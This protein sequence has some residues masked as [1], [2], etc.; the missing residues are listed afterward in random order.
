[1]KLAHALLQ[2]L[3]DYGAEEIFGIPGDFALP[4]FR[5]IERSNI[6]P[7]YTLS[8]EPAVG[9]AADSAA[10]YRSS[11]SVA[12]VTYGAGGLNMINPVAQAYAEKSPVVI[13]SGAPGANEGQ[14]GLGLHHQVKHLGTQLQVFSEV[15]CAQTVLDDPVQ[16]P[17]EIAR[18]LT[19]AR[20]LSRPVYIEFPRDKVDA[21]VP[22][23]PPF[24]PS[25]TD[26]DAARAAA[27][28]ILVRLAAAQNPALL[29]CVEVRRYG[30][31]RK[32]EELAR[33][34]AIPAATTFMARGI[35]A[36][37]DAPFIGTY[38]GLAGD[39]SVR[40]AIEGSDALLMLGVILC[41]TNFG[42]SEKLIDRRRSMH[43]FDRNVRI[44]HHVYPDV[45]LPALIDALLEHAK[46]LGR[47]RP[48]P[49]PDYTRLM[50]KDTQ[51]V[52][53]AD[54]A[55]AV[56]D[57]FDKHGRMPI[58]CDMGDCLFT[59]MDIMYTELVA[60]AYYGTM[61]P[62]VPMGLGMQ[63]ASGKRGL[64]MVGDGAFQMTGWE[65]GNARRLGLNPIVLVLNNAA[66]GMLKVLQEGTHYN[67]LDEWRFAELGTALGGKGRRVATRAELAEALEAAHADDS[68][69]HLVEIMI[70]RGE[71]S[72]TLSRF[73]KAM[74]R[75]SVLGK[76]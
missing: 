47:P 39:D 45:P 6:L 68:T 12:A 9:F 16:A 43:A 18:V 70:P 59:A 26:P 41:D 66:W 49:W 28:E 76:G 44:A 8:H 5:E 42:V 67:D 61:G 55:T 1:M 57:L 29:I 34:L 22:A 14:L 24:V 35:L 53:P 27:S 15:T 38:L 58:A 13:V 69:W 71:Y 75:R 36:G 19:A 51:P 46:P 63:V 54:V 7:L 62:G 31:E 56:N 3:K 4:F 30:L 65:L 74:K 10:R 50:P 33:I 32:V 73:V 23:V 37:A 17:R 11:L 2:G 21:E 20:E 40:G 25:P 64:I 72:H 48:A 52:R 60:P